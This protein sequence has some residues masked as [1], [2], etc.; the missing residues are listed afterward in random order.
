MLEDVTLTNEV[1]FNKIASS[2]AVRHGFEEVIEAQI[3]EDSIVRNKILPTKEVSINDRNVQFDMED[4]N[5]QDIYYIVFQDQLRPGWAMSANMRGDGNATVVRDKKFKV[6]FSAITTE[7]LTMTDEDALKTVHNYPEEYSK[8]LS[9]YFGMVE[10]RE[11]VLHLNAAIEAMAKAKGFTDPFKASVATSCF[12]AVKGT[13]VVD[14][15]YALH[16]ISKADLVHLDKLFIG[17]TGQAYPASTLLI[18]TFDWKD[19]ALWGTEDVG[20]NGPRETYE[21]GAPNKPIV[22]WK[23]VI[24]TNKTGIIRNGNVY[25]MSPKNLRGKFLIFMAPRTYTINYGSRIE[26]WSKE[27]VGQ[28]FGNLY[29]FKKLELFGGAVINNASPDASVVPLDED[30]L[31]QD[32]LSPEQV[33]PVI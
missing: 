30:E 15:T 28:Y 1:F 31:I 25:A 26:M 4:P 19:I 6:G 22:G 24:K 8:R 16:S 14:D 5:S 29:A 23:E 2:P 21:R 13:N 32:T 7:H 17:D 20:A 33:E 18:T 12:S 9:F 10:D 11:F 27:I 3:L